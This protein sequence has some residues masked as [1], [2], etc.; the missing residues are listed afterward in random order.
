MQT[1]INIAKAVLYVVAAIIIAL[2]CMLL[3]PFVWLL[4]SSVG[5]IMT[6]ALL[7]HFL[8]TISRREK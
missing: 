1:L 7:I 4:G 3:A 8:I 5:V 6:T 2:L